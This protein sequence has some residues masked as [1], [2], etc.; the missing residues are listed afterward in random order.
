MM[1][2]F[3]KRGCP[4]MSDA[5]LETVHPG[6]AHVD[7]HDR[8]VLPEQQVEAPHRRSR[9]ARGFLQLGEDRLVGE[10]LGRLI[11]DQ[12]YV[13]RLLAAHRCSHTRSERQQLLGVDRLGDVV[14][15]A[16][17]EAFLAVALHGLGRER[18]DRQPAEARVLR[19][20]RMVS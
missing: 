5:E 12:Q 7:Q 19:I 16:G 3:W 10:H 6:H 8:D 4:W 11:V 9:P 20:S 1:A 18:D 17:L 13:D 2:V 15:G 14:G